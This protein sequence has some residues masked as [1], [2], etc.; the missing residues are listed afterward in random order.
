MRYTSIR[1]PGGTGYTAGRKIFK[2]TD[3]PWKRAL[4]IG[5][6]S[7]IGEELA[8]QLAR[9]GCRVALAARRA[10]E[11][12]R[13][14]AGINAERGE[15]TALTF[16]HDVL[17]T[18]CVPALFQKIAHDLGGLDLVIYASGIMPLMQPD[19]YDFGKDEQMVEVNILGAVAWLNEAA[20]RFGR[21]GAGTLI[22]I[23]SVAGD[24]GRR[25]M[26][27]YGATKAF[28]ATYL[29]SLRNRIGRTGAVVVTVKPGPVATPMTSG[30]DQKKLPLLITADKAAT[31]IL[32]AAARKRNLVYVPGA[33]RPI[34]FLI[35]SVPSFLFRKLNI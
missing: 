33:W 30:M 25:G 18:E 20:Q 7:G 21:A 14:A 22:G 29:E 3:W 13:I 10:D 9:G 19:E 1:S 12:T 16:P 26:P 15:G 24:R 27:V 5:A 31:L 4:I 28:L 35:R 11:L 34:M 8:R 6:S 32:D 17:E 23:G 2:L